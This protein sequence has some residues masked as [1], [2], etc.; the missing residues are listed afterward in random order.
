MTVAEIVLPTVQPELAGPGIRLRPW[1]R[2]DVPA[3]VAACQDPMTV[4]YTSIPADFTEDDALSLIYRKYPAGYESGTAAAFAVVDAVDDTLLGFGGL[5]RLAL[6]P[7][8]AEV[9]YWVAPSARGRGV[10][11]AATGV[12]V[13]WA[14]ELGFERLELL[15]EP[16]NE[17]SLVVAQRSGFRVEG[18]LREYSEIRGARRDLVMHSLL[19]REWDPA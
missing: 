12:L 7:K 15:A 18:V 8:R 6:L 14:F 16:D 10:A 13:A 19:R 4:H 9:G 3:M 1:R 5:V 17:G 2:D 11:V